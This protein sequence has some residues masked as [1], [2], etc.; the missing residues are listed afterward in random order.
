M[1][2][3]IWE[4]RDDRICA[5]CAN[6]AT[7][8][9]VRIPLDDGHVAERFLCRHAVFYGEAGDGC[10]TLVAPESDCIGAEHPAF[11]PLSAYKRSIRRE[12]EE[13]SDDYG[14]RPGLDHPAT[15]FAEPQRCAV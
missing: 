15:L 11:V 8:I 6:F 5:N 4:D 7:A 14:V 2:R 12:A 9:P 10:L 13:Y 1:L 3:E